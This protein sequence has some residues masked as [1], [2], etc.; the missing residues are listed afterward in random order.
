MMDMGFRVSEYLF[1]DNK[2]RELCIINDFKWRR[3]AM[4]T[5][6]AVI[7]EMESWSLYFMDQLS[8]MANQTVNVMHEYERE[9][10]SVCVYVIMHV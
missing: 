5:I 7:R 8:G 6:V 10:Q 1:Y 4:V 2:E 3:D 9:C